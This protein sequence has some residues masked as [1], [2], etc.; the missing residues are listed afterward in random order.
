MQPFPRIE[1][2]TRVLTI[3]TKKKWLFSET[4]TKQIFKKKP[5]DNSENQNKYCLKDGKD[6]QY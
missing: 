4:P 5:N 6:I 1:A 3:T 2:K